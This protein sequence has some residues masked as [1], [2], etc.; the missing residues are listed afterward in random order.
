M[1]VNLQLNSITTAVLLMDSVLLHSS[2]DK[3]P[4]IDPTCA[5]L[6]SLTYEPV[7]DSLQA[8][9]ATLGRW[10][11]YAELFEDSKDG[12][13]CTL[14]EPV[15]SNRTFDVNADGTFVLYL[16]DSVRIGN[17]ELVPEFS[18]MPPGRDPREFAREYGLSPVNW[19]AVVV[20]DAE[21]RP[22]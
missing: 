10:Y 18:G 15:D 14:Y 11:R 17:W 20:L 22:A 21:G 19:S 1:R 7:S 2:C 12:T 13:T 16:M 6:A 5:A 9:N 3:E 4:S 8:Y